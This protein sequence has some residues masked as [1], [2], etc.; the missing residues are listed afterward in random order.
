MYQPHD[1]PDVLKQLG[2][3]CIQPK[4]FL[5]ND[6]SFITI[7][8]D[9]WMLL[10]KRLPARESDAALLRLYYVYYPNDGTENLDEVDVIALVGEEIFR[11]AD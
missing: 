8:A 6:G 7:Q 9:G 3:R 2:F 11:N 1:S 5:L 10:E 4:K